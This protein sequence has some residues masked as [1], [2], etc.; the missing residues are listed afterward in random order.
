MDVMHA[1]RVEYCPVC[2]GEFPQA[3]LESHAQSHFSS[4]EPAQDPIVIGDD[5]EE[6]SEVCPVSGCGQEIPLSELASHKAAHR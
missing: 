3:M 5:V 2:F 1:D 6:Q 4:P